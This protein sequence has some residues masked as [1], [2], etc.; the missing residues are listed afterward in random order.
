VLVAGDVPLAV[1]DLCLVGPIGDPITAARSVPLSYLERCTLA[2]PS[3]PHALRALVDDACAKAS[4]K[5]KAPLEV[6]SLATMKAIVETGSCHTV[7]TY[8]AVAYEVGGHRLQA[9][10][11]VRPALSRLLVMSLAPK[12]SLTMAARTMSDLICDIVATAIA[13]KRWQARLP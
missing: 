8:D 1:S 7:C 2:L 3:H 5:L 9:A 12:H 11:I 13:E 4:L 6:D 10:L